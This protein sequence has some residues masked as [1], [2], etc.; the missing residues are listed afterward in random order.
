[1]K[2]FN[3]YLFKTRKYFDSK[4][5]DQLPVHMSK[6]DIGLQS[7]HHSKGKSLIKGRSGAK[8]LVT[9]F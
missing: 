8:E 6:P 5:R 9:K 4:M 3:K 7:P 2:A 1:L